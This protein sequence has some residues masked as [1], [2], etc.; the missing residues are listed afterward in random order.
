M[1]FV[2]VYQAITGQKFPYPNSVSSSLKN[3]VEHK[4][5][6]LEAWL[7][8]VFC[9]TLWIIHLLS[10]ILGN[11]W[12]LLFY[13]SI[14]HKIGARPNLIVNE[15][16]FWRGVCWNKTKKPHQRQQKNS[17]ISEADDTMPIQNVLYPNI[18]FKVYNIVIYF[19][20]T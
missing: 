11:L 19:N 20:H 10:S 8:D 1:V 4:G 2:C 15:V 12:P 5:V 16:P 9:L 6:K 17:R 13:T 3:K 7:C 18:N 14:G